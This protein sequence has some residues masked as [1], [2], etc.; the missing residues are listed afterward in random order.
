MPTPNIAPKARFIAWLALAGLVTTLDQW[1]KLIVQANLLDYETKTF[2]P[3]FNLYLTYNKGAAF[4][5]LNS[6]SGWQ[7]PFFITL[8][9]IASLF[10][11]YL[12]WRN[13]LKTLLSTGLSLIMG[14]ALGNVIDRLQHGKVTDFLQFHL[15][16]H[17]FPAFNLADSAIFLGVVL[18]LLDG[19]RSPK[20]V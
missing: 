19:W 18:V 13:P 10:I 3:F 7:I 20:S 5:F 8:A 14:G 6:A 4:S 16:T 9:S 12:L 17:Y 1:S 11:T 15:N 2:T